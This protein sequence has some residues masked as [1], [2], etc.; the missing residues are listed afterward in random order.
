MFVTFYSGM[1]SHQTPF[2]MKYYQTWMFYQLNS[3]NWKPEAL[4]FKYHLINIEIGKKYSFAYST[5]AYS[6]QPVT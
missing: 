2:S 6:T 4:E 1:N 5:C 3:E